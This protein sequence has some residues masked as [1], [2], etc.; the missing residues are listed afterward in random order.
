[1]PSRFQFECGSGKG[2]FHFPKADSLV[3]K[4]DSVSVATL[5]LCEKADHSRFF[6]LARTTMVERDFLFRDQLLRKKNL[7]PIAT[8]HQG[9]RGG[10]EAFPIGIF[11]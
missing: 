4:F 10:E 5:S 7:G 11:S 8:Q 9:L 1:M 6:I 3:Q 2:E